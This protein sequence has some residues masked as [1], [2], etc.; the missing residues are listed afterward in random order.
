MC[1]LD[2]LYS[3]V[4]KLWLQLVLFTLLFPIASK[5]GQLT[6]SVKINQDKIFYFIFDNDATFRVD[7][8]YTQGLGATH[9]NPVFRKSVV[10]K[11]LM[12]VA[13]KN[14][15]SFYGLAY[16][17]DGFTPTNI[18]DPAIRIGDRPYAAYMYFSQIAGTTDQSRQMRFASSLDVGMI[19]PVAGAGRFQRVI[20]EYLDHG[21]PR[22][23][24][25]QIK[26]DLVLNYNLNY[27]K[28]LIHT[29]SL[30]LIGEAEA[31]VGTLYTRASAGALLRVGWLNNYFSDLGISNRASRQS[32]GLRNFQL[33][34]FA[35]SQGRLVGYN[36][37]M[38]GGVLN[39]KNVYTLPAS[40]ISRTVLE[41]QTGLVCLIKGLRLESAVSFISPE[42]RGSRSHKWMHFNVGFAF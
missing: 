36:A 30:E 33:F 23:W 29:A 5:A 12:K 41:S 42:F 37:T 7:Y 9:Y 21:I 4:G 24:K 11:V 25:Y 16:K 1:Q 19:G 40:A 26:N 6:D 32:A 31:S 13:S 27:Q 2:L 39:N 3:A 20:H 17:Y 10:N 38:Q 14:A 18:R 8:Y 35:R 15:E 22:G 34:A 28:G